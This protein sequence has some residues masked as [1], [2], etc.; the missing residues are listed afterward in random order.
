MQS[1]FNRSLCDSLNVMCLAILMACSEDSLSRNDNQYDYLDYSLDMMQ[2]D[3]TDVSLNHDLDQHSEADIDYGNE[4]AH[5]SDLIC[6]E[7]SRSIDAYTLSEHRL[8]EASGLA[9]SMISPHSLWSHNDSSDD[10]RVFAM[11]DQGEIFGEMIIKD[12]SQDLEDIDIARCPH[13]DRICI[14]LADVGDNEKVR[15]H[16]SIYIVPEPPTGLPFEAINQQLLTQGGEAL[17]ISFV[18]QGGPADIEALV[19]HHEGH[20]LWLFEK[21]QGELSRI[22]QLDLSVLEMEQVLYQGDDR[23]EATLIGEFQ[24]PGISVEHGQKITAADLSPLGQHLLIRVYTGI[25]EYAL[26]HPYAFEDLTII[27]PKLILLGPLSEPQGE[28]ITYGWQGQGLWTVSE[29][30]EA[31][32]DLHYLGC[33]PD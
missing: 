7:Y 6:E 22:W 29:S 26:S 10:T 25:Y 32:Q 28:S 2:A 31:V 23:L 11:S 24:A 3:V 17:K 19:V 30:Q 14:W 18:L 1:R 13:L 20:T 16:L 21:I 27:D 12:E 4:V 8:P 9:F 5:V 15:D 33:K